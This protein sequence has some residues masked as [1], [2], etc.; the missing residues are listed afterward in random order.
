MTNGWVCLPH[1]SYHSLGNMIYEYM[2]G[3]VCNGHTNNNIIILW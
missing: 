3:I 2:R 1:H